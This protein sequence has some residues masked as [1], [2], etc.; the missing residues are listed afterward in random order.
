MLAAKRSFGSL[1]AAARAQQCSPAAP[2]TPS[3]QRSFMSAVLLSRDQF[4]SKTVVELKKQLSERGLSTKGKKKDLVDRLVDSVSRGTLGPNA[5][6]S[7]SASSPSSTSSINSSKISPSQQASA[8]FSTTSRTPAKESPSN[9]STATGKV[10]ESATVEVHAPAAEAAA[11]ATPVTPPPSDEVTAGPGLLV[12]KEEAAQVA[13]TAEEVPGGTIEM[14][15]AVFL[16][17]I[18]R[19]I[20]ESQ[21]EMMIPE[22]PHMYK[23]PADHGESANELRHTSIYHPRC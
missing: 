20:Q 18:E 21:H 11:Q 12:N 8:A 17:S 5:S 15:N 14:P 2:A 13:E 9:A 4:S 22:M 19:D 10:V 3:T 7:T 6:I 16:P 23:N 1:R